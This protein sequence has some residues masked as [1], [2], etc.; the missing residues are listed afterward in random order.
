MLET[1]RQWPMP[2]K[3]LGVMLVLF[4]AKGVLFTFVMAP[5]SG[6][7]EVAHFA[8]LDY[9]ATE[10]RLPIIPVLADWQEEYEE[11][12]ER[13]IHDHIPPELFPYCR[14]VTSDWFH[15]CS[16]PDAQP[17]YEV[18][19]PMPE[20]RVVAPS[21][22]VYT[23]NHPPLYYLAMLPV[24]WLSSG[25]S[26]E[27][28][29]YLL[30]LAAIPFGLVT[31]FC[32]WFTAQLMF[33]K[34]W[35]ITCL[36]TAFVTFQPQVSYE[37]AMFNNDIVSIALTSV[38][39]CLLALGIRTGFPW[40]LCVLTGFAFGLAML[41]KNTSIVAGAV[42]AFAMILGLGVRNW[43]MWLPRGCIA[44]ATAGL[45]IWPW[46]FYMWITYRNLTALDRISDLQ[47]FWNY[48]G[49]D[50]PTVLAQLSDLEFAQ[51]R[52]SETW[53]EFGWRLIPLDQGLLNL[54]LLG[55]G[56]SVAGALLW[57]F[58]HMTHF[59]L[60]QPLLADRASMITVAMLFFACI[61]S[62]YAVLQ[63]GTTFSLTQARYYFPAID[64][65]A[66]LLALGYR[67]ITPTSWRP[68]VFAILLVAMAGLNFVIFSEY[69]IPYWQQG[70]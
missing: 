66:I 29:L 55:C 36:A 39:L 19:W 23:A 48:Q 68:A 41:A 40:R 57:L 43:Q 34:D 63:F 20:G 59:Q 47:H 44:L 16:V 25:G 67:A 38:I 15:G 51:A 60:S 12:R 18:V 8:Y 49:Q 61:V 6:H 24:Y 10:G 9:L 7:D 17:T 35:F 42:I 26:V 45:L 22:W 30:R 65:A 28:Q 52:W 14:F 54:I 37:S 46:Y 11:T 53:G 70:L 21:G 33:P 3:F 31:V 56:I 64:A 1:W 62:Y 13:R 4:L 58:Q 27:T 5:F 32:A 50:P 2:R 69:L